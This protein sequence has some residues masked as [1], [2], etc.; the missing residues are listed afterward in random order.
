LYPVFL[1]CFNAANRRA[2]RRV[3]RGRR[4]SGWVAGTAF[5]GR[6]VRNATRFG[7]LAGVIDYS[8]QWIKRPSFPSD[9]SLLKTIN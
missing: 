5:P 8:I 9:F 3:L 1:Q 7:R 6:K 2:G 4:A